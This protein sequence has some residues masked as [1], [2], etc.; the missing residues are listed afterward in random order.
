MEPISISAI[1]CR[2]F[3][4]S[5]APGRCKQQRPGRVPFS[6]Y[7]NAE[8]QHSALRDVNLYGELRR[9]IENELAEQNA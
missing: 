6:G 8:D 4:G 2:I 7:V 1:D 3:N 5:H 9:T